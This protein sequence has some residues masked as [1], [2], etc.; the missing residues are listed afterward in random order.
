M[1]EK[2]KL[3]EKEKNKLGGSKTEA[4]ADTHHTDKETN[5][6]IPSEEAVEDAKHWVEDNEK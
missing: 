4:W 2:N 6:S 3:E 5:V 1:S